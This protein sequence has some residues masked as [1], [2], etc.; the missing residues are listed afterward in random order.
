M[1]SGDVEVGRILEGC[2]G[3]M[4][5]GLLVAVVMELLTGCTVEGRT[6]G[7]MNG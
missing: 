3:C 6:T 2:V 1:I 4:V 7:G 5:G